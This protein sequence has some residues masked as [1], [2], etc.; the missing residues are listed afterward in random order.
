MLTICWAETY[1]FTVSSNTKALL[2][3]SKVS[4][5]A[6]VETTKYTLMLRHK[7]ARQDY[8]VKINDESFENVVKLKCLGP[9]V[10]YRNCVQKKINSCLKSGDAFYH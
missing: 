4:L 10:T 1:R 7:N 3:A 5:D 6:T 8:N 9:P 2:H